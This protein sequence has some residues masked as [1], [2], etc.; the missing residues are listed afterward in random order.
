MKLQATLLLCAALAT[1]TA[2]LTRTPIAHGSHAPKAST[3]VWQVII[4]GGAWGSAVPVRMLDD[5]TVLFLTARHVAI[6]LE[7][8]QGIVHDRTKQRKLLVLKHVDHQTADLSVL[9]VKSDGGKVE[10]VQ[11]DLKMKAPSGLSVFSVGYPGPRGDLAIHR[12]YVGMWPWTSSYIERGMSGGAMVSNGGRLIAILRGHA[13][14]TEVLSVRTDA[15]DPSKV[16]GFADWD[17]HIPLH[18]I[19]VPLSPH[20]LWLEQQKV[21]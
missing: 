2:I 13:Y 8:G 4:K 1:P 12:G 3:S 17:K 6:Q 16:T 9:H 15:T 21:L 14:D 19:V 18:S 5:G 10:L 7:Q 11:I 20:K